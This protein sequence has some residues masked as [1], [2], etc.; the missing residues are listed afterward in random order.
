M[1][2]PEGAK[3]LAA[4]SARK[5]VDE[6]G[7]EAIRYLLLSTHYR[8]PIDF[9]ETTLAN[10]KKALSTFHR[11]FERLQRLATEPKPAPD[12]SQPPGPEPDMDRAASA[13]L[14]GP[15]APFAKAVLAL[16]MKFLEMMD[17]DFNTAGAIG[18]LHEIAGE[19]NSFLEKNQVERNRHPD[20]VSAAAAGVQTLR[21]LGGVLGLFVQK[22]TTPAAAGAAGGQAEGR[23]AKVMDLVL[24]VRQEM[25]KSKNFEVAD[26]IRK[27]LTDAGIT[28]ED[29]PQGTR[30]RVG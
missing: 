9:S 14:E 11:L 23:L 10:A 21:N 26:E 22:P 4:V 6:H 2:D 12:P 18:A 20:L 3:A 8:S 30:W 7:A 1:W 27:R 25:R 5:L 28:L 15:H 24:W 19:V 17:D 13:L 16:K 29:D